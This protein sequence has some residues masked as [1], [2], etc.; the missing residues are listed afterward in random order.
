M[1]KSRMAKMVKNKDPTTCRPPDAPHIRAL[2]RPLAFFCSRSL[3][4]KTLNKINELSN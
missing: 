1:E 3:K 2:G 4:K